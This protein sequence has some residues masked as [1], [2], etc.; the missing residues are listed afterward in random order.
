MNGL[1]PLVRVLG[2]AAPYQSI[3]WWRRSWLHN[4]RTRAICTYCQ[5][6]LGNDSESAPICQ[7]WVVLLI[8]LL[9]QM[10]HREMALNLRDETLRSLRWSWKER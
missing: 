4:Y 7:L 1:E 6:H 3:E 2:E 5:C 8:S 10:L 9:A